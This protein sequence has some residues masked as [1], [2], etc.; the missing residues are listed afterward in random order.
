MLWDFLHHF[1]DV[2]FLVSFVILQKSFEPVYFYLYTIY[3]LQGLQ[4]SALYIFAWSLS[5]SW[6]SGVMAAA[7]FVLNKL[8]KKILVIFLYL[9]FDAVIC[10]YNHPVKIF[11]LQF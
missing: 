3:S 1:V 4:L 6:L 7:L 9:N 10:Y 8:V 2:T 11:S 5:G